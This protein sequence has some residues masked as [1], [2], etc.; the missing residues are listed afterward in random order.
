ML[1]SA[2]TKG[3]ASGINDSLTELKSMTE[4]HT[5][6]YY[7]HI[8]KTDEGGF[9]AGYTEGDEEFAPSDDDT[10]LGPSN[11]TVVANVKSVSEGGTE[12]TTPTEIV[13]GDESTYITIQMK[14][15]DGSY[16][17]CPES[18][19][20]KNGDVTDYT[21]VLVKDTGLHYVD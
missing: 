18:F 3:L 13:A 10:R 12:S 21:V 4:A 6:P 19:E 17:S 2:D 16:E 20:V 7:L 14:K 15:K 9:F 11:L 1:R 8:Y 5:G